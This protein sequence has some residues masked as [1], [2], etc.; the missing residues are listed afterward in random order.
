MKKRT[1]P[2]KVFKPYICLVCGG[3][4]IVHAPIA[5]NITIDCPGCN[6]GAVYAER[7]YMNGRRVA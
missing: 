3:S 5:A 7:R 6:D 2:L 4:G 1:R